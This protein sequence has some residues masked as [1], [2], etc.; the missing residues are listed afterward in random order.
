MPKMKTIT[1]LLQDTISYVKKLLE[2]FVNV[3]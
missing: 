1:H 2:C 3:V